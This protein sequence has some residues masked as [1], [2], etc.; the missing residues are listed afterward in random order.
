MEVR[1]REGSATPSSQASPIEQWIRS[2]EHEVSCCAILCPHASNE[3]FSVP[4]LNRNRGHKRPNEF[5]CYRNES[6]KTPS[7]RMEHITTH[8]MPKILSLDGGGAQGLSSLLILREIMEDVERRMGSDETPKRCEYFDL[9]AS[10]FEIRIERSS[11]LR[12][13]P[14]MHT[15]ILRPPEKP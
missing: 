3:P 11:S 14:A 8:R 10:S 12:E 2:A 13:T 6:L 1:R 5:G 7:E 15:Y 9:L 4:D